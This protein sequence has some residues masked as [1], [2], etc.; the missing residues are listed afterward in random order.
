[1]IHNIERM[2][3]EVNRAWFSFC[4]DD[5]QPAFD[6]AED[7]QIKSIRDVVFFH[8]NQ[9][10][11]GKIPTAS[12]FHDEWM[13]CKI[14]DGWSWGPEKNPEEKKHPL[15]VPYKSLSFEQK[16]KDFLF[17]SIV[18]S[19]WNIAE[20]EV[21]LK[22]KSETRLRVDD[23][24]P[25]IPPV[26]CFPSHKEGPP[27]SGA[28]EYIIKL[29]KGVTEDG[30]IIPSEKEIYIPFLQRMN[31][32]SFREGIVHE[33]V[34]VMQKN[35]LFKVNMM[36]PSEHTQNIISKLTECLELFSL[37]KKERKEQGKLGKLEK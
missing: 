20:N 35:S 27:Y 7:W 24:G 30:K 33:Q 13:R 34:V 14:K 3:Y 18:H 19:F 31:D 21:A 37:R 32:G 6:D 11:D 15:I 29:A 10:K 17:S 26:Y 23:F 8:L 5:S 1:M 2:V 36:F 12:D 4:G 16:V 22:E 28:H 25:E 9:L